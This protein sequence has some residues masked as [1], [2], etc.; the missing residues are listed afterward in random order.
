MSI[1]QKLTA[2]TKF[3]F[4]GFDSAVDYMLNTVLNPYLSVNTV[5]A[6]V[7][8]AYETALSVYQF[9]CK[10][11]M[12]CPACWRS[13]YDSILSAL[14]TMIA[15][16]EDGQVTRDEISKCVAA[17]QTAKDAWNKE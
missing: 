14:E 1:W 17:L 10:Y 15:T 4:G 8:K 5:A 3:L 6:K 13:Y 2:G 9:L 11:A 7:K 12:Y 16:F